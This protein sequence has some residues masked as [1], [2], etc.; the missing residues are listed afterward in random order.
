MSQGRLP[1][2]GLALVALGSTLLALPLPA[3]ADDTKNVEIAPPPKPTAALSARLSLAGGTTSWQ[4]DVLGYGGLALGVRLFDVIT[5]F[6]DVRLGYGRVDQRLLTQLALGVEGG[7]SLSSTIYPHARF[8]FVHQHE[9]SMASVAEEPFGAV[10]GIGKGIRH[11]AGVVFGLGCDV[12]FFR[13]PKISL[14]A[15]PELSGAWLTYSSGPS[16][17]GFVGANLAM[18]IPLF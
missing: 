1:T 18:H 10:L 13:R 16:L 15:G 6:V 2:L 9:E 17:Y 11:R 7:W 4:K 5:P 12:Q 8:G 3:H 14:S